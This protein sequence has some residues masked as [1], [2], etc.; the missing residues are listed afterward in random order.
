MQ[1]NEQL[2]SK[3]AERGMLTAWLASLERGPVTDLEATAI[4]RAQLERVT[5]EIERMEDAAGRSGAATVSRRPSTS[6][7]R[8]AGREDRPEARKRRSPRA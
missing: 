8:G 7:K 6:R 5:R 2:A 4:V 3:Y 1:T